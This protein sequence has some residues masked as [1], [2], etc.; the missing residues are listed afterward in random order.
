MKS[1]FMVQHKHFSFI[2]LTTSEHLCGSLGAGDSAENRAES[3]F[4]CAAH[5]LGEDERITKESIDVQ[6]P[7][8]EMSVVKI[9]PS[10]E[11]RTGGRDAVFVGKVEKSSLQS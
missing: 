2:C 4:P 3:L 6:C 11:P 7:G 5:L 1:W 10:E 8:D 9:R